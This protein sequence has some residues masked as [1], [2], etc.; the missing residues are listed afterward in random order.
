MIRLAYLAILF[1]GILILAL[2]ML[3]WCEVYAFQKRAVFTT[4]T[5]VQHEAGKRTWYPVVEFRDQLGKAHRFKGKVTSFIPMPPV[6]DSV[7]V[8]FDPTDDAQSLNPRIPAEMWSQPLVTTVISF[9]LIAF[10]LHFR[11]RKH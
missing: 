6:G 3:R 8:A 11:K 9:P 2:G 7:A 1:A 5:I 4:G 10:G